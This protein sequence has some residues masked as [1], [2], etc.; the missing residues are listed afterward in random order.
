MCVLGNKIVF[1]ALGV[2]LISIFVTHLAMVLKR[3][4]RITAK[5]LL[6]CFTVKEIGVL[7]E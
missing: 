6:I 5:T 7:Y 1:P 3:F 2:I 4:Y